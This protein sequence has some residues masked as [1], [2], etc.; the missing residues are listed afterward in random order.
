[1]LYFDDNKNVEKTMVS[2]PLAYQK[3]EEVF[4][5]VT[6]V[7]KAFKL[8]QLQEEIILTLNTMIL[9]TAEMI[10]K[11]INM[12]QSY[13]D[14]ESIAWEVEVLSKDLY[15]NKYDFVDENGNHSK[16][17]LYA[18]GFRGKGWLNTQSKR[19]YMTGFLA[20]KNVLSF[21]KIL[22]TNKLLLELELYKDYECNM[23][24]MIYDT[25]EISNFAF[26][27]HCLVNRKEN[28][29]IIEVIRGENNYADK[30]VTK[31]K[32]ISNT[33][34]NSDSSELHNVEVLYIAENEEQMLALLRA[35]ND[36]C[37]EDIQLWFTH[38]E[39]IVEKHDHRLYK[40]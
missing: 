12:T 15:L 26:R 6:Q 22:A 25:E 19:P 29:L 35:I 34:A 37:K 40:L 31:L 2:S 1:M 36:N 9:A 4:E 5:Y 24:K 27:A 17:K 32:R 14:I 38:D 28:P 7:G 33:L 8:S 11:Y 16:D 23:C 18:V 39:L 20:Q 30:A 10:S 21:K 3:G 13:V